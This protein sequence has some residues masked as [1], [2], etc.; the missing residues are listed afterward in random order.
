MVKPQAHYTDQRIERIVVL[1][2]GPNP[3]TDIYLRNRLAGAGLP[4]ADFVDIT[5]CPEDRD[6]ILSKREGG[7]FVIVCR[8]ISAGWL[9]ALEA[10]RPQLAGLAYFVDDDLPAMLAD[11]SLPL[12]YRFRIWRRYARHVDRLSALASRL[13]VAT[14]A[15]AEK[16]HDQGAVLLPPLYIDSPAETGRMTRYFY[17][18]TAAHEAEKRF[19]VEVVR[20]VQRRDSRMLFEI[21]GDSKT[22]EL[23]RG[24]E[25][26]V[27]LHPMDWPAYLA[28]SSSAR[29][30]IGLAPLFESP[31]NA[32]RSHS[33]VYDITRIGAV[34]I[35]SDCTPY[36]DF[37]RDGEDGVLLPDETGQWVEAILELA[38]NT[39]R[40]RTMALAARARCPADDDSF[41]NLFGLHR[42]D[43]LAQV[44]GGRSGSG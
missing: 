44:A 35:Y 6:S 30:D 37:I 7:V 33:R 29:Q 31:V 20:E 9:D 23:F 21:V 27:V 34:G 13:W 22:R 10:A 40:R 15:L 12:R 4:P 39:G 16:Y 18:G 41:R 1:H 2:D 38:A 11:R 24:I 36:A 28:Y 5:T 43:S 42:Q 19:L 26:V 25:R 8:Y 3:S 14:P 32:V 17:H